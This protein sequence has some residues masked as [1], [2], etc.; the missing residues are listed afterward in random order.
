MTMTRKKKEKKKRRNNL[1]ERWKRENK[2][3]G[4]EKKEGSSHDMLCVYCVAVGLG[5]K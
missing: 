1:F 5:R 2:N 3:K 4:R